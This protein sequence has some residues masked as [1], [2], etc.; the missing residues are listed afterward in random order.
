MNKAVAVVLVCA[1]VVAAVIF[2]YSAEL[3]IGNRV[4]VPEFSGVD[5][6][7]TV[8]IHD[9]DYRFTKEGNTLG[10]Y[11][12]LSYQEAMAAGRTRNTISNPQEGE[13]YPW[14]GINI[15]ILEVHTDRYVISVTSRD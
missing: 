11:P 4:V 10:V 13:T 8:T 3:G 5:S 15:K 14:L 1:G 7:V 2:L 6:I 12:W 9:V